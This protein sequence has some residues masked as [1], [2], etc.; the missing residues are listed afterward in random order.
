MCWQMGRGK[1][2]TP[3]GPWKKGKKN[4]SS[5]FKQHRRGPGVSMR[6]GVGASAGAGA[7][8]GLF[9]VGSAQSQ[10]FQA[11]ASTFSNPRSGSASLFNRNQRVLLVGE[12]D[13]SFAAAL[14]LSFGGSKITATSFD[15]GATCREKYP[16]TAAVNIHALVEAGADVR[17]GV[18]AT[19]L[20]MST[21]PWLAGTRPTSG[22]RSRTRRRTH[23]CWRRL[24]RRRMEES[25]PRRRLRRAAS[26]CSR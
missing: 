17:H 25:P 8:G 20:N 12:G 14:A 26:T 10:L 22:I 24:R 6:G 11:H 18:D 1:K 15:S 3:K 19:A 7:G 4:K 21:M 9:V 2:F 23:R 5:G 16:A 13:F